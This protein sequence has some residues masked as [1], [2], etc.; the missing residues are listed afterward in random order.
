MAHI[1]G[2]FHG[3]LGVVYSSTTQI[4]NATEWTYSET[5]NE[6]EATAGGDTAKSY[7]AGLPDGGGSVTT[8]WDPAD[9]GQ[10][11]M[12]IGA[13]VTLNLYPG[14]NTAGITKLSGSVVITGRAIDW[15]YEGVPSFR[16]DYRGFLTLGTI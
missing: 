8:R 9:A 5:G 15:S 11:A 2:P 6:V 12:T 4:A 16:F 7:L 1:N 14:G 10:T 13:S 3:K